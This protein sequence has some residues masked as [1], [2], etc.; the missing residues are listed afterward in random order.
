MRLPLRITRLHG[1][2]A[3]RLNRLYQ[4]TD[5]PRTRLRVQMVLLSSDRHSVA[6]IAG[7]TRQ[8][9]DTV[10]HWLQR[11]LED[12][13]RGLLEAPRSGRPAAITP[14]AEQ[15]LLECLHGSPRDFGLSRPTWTTDLLAQL[16]WRRLK[17][18][19]TAECIRQHLLRLDGVC[20]RP[21]WTVKHLARQRPGYAQKKA[22]LQGFC[23]T[24]RAVPTSTFKMKPN[25]VCFRHLPACGC[26]AASNARSARRGCIPPNVTSARPPIGALARSFAFARKSAMP[27]PSAEWLR[28]AWPA[29]RVVSGV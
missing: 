29:R 18:D 17:I 16:V 26:C 2:Q 15:F 6:E 1:R 23:S 3:A 5:C 20:R 21:N 22:G 8:S 11:F 9:D 12:G 4:T 7:I 28:N 10:R 19:V 24:L 13:W 25:S 27:P 14:A